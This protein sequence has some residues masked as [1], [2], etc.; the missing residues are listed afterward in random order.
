M[1]TPDP[2]S[3]GSKTLSQPNADY[4]TLELKLWVCHWSSFVIGASTNPP[5]P[6]IITYTY[7][8]PSGYDLAISFLR[9]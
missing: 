9:S 5:Q 2:Y 1:L 8:T 6:L 3:L 7:S 4:D